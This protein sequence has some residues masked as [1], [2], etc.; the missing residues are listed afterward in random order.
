MLESNSSRLLHFRANCL[1]WAALNHFLPANLLRELSYVL[2]SVIG[3]GKYELNQL[4]EEVMISGPDGLESWAVTP[5]D[6]SDPVAQ[7][8]QHR[9]RY[10][11]WSN[12]GEVFYDR[13][14]AQS[15]DVIGPGSLEDAVVLGHI[16]LGVLEQAID[17][18]KF[19]PQENIWSLVAA[20]KSSRDLI[21]LTEQPAL[22]QEILKLCDTIEMPLAATIIKHLGDLS[23]DDDRWANALTFYR[24]CLA[25][26]ST[27]KAENW[28]EY[29]HLLRSITVQSIAAALRIIDGP[30]AA[31]SFLSPILKTAD[32]G[33]APFFP[34]NASLD[35]LVAESLSSESARFPSDRRASI[36]SEPLLLRSLDLSSAFEAWLEGEFRN[37]NRSFWSV[38]RRQIALGSANDAR[39]TKAFY[40]KSIFSELE[41][42]SE[43]DVNRDSFALAVRLFVQSGQE[44][45]AKKM[46]WSERLVRAYVDEGAVALVVSQTSNF[47]A[48]RDER[49]GVAVE[50][51]RGW[52]LALPAE[53]VGLAASMLR[54]VCMVAATHKSSFFGPRNVGGRSIEVLREVAD[55]R[56]EF[57]VGIR[58]EVV[59]AV[60][61][62]F[63]Q[64]EFWTGTAEALKT[65]ARYLD[66]LEEN[67][68]RAI[69]SA[70]LS[71]LDRTDPLRDAWVI[72]QPALALLVA[73]QVQDLTRK[74]Q[75]LGNRIIATI[76]RFGINQKTEHTWLLFYLSQFGWK[77]TDHGAAR[78]QIEAVVQHVREQALAIN[79]SNSV[80]N[81]RALLLGSSIAGLEGVKDALEALNR[82]LTSTVGAERRTSLSFPFAYEALLILAQRQEKIAQD[83]SVG[84]ED[85]RVFLRPLLELVVVVWRH[86]VKN[87]LIFA[88]FAWP[89]RSKPSPVVIHNW[90]FA[91]IAFAKSLGEQEKIAQVLNMA[92]EEPALKHPIALARAIRLAPGELDSFDSATIR[93]DDAETFYSAL[94]Q[95]LVALEHLDA[96]V[97]SDIL[98][99]MLYQCLRYGPHGLDAAVFLTAGRA[100][101]ESLKDTPEYANYVQRVRNDRELRLALLP[102]LAEQSVQ[103]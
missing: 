100:R 65:S 75:A 23:A 4:F 73:S 13:N 94:G 64:G 19:P 78:E 16:D 14:R 15:S 90:A 102:F 52:A 55:R 72:V 36:Q 84:D 89:P 39:T 103:K 28:R 24:Q 60:L 44:N 25:R 101:I 81:I 29:I 21:N 40:A 33:S 31:A 63:E 70:T 88:P 51:M 8:L 66:V 43:S 30:A 53:R 3:E 9:I 37:S 41:S 67:D 1:A 62:K 46:D 96:D 87:P 49:M 27:D 76:L 57:R 68:I 59:P 54:F 93:S 74:D 6:V 86:A 58:S 82:I 97:R 20:I 98:G 10:F 71:L 50:F 2:V 45:L 42:K 22:L 99:A 47:E 92:A 56:P 17:N 38:L 35:A 48:S 80:D 32:F 7:Y 79:A 26:L 85:F 61:S 34:L 18:L 91:S 95:R 12:D 11:I 77:V 83:I 69:V 5:L